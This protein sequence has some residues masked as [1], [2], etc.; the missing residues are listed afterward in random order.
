MGY[1]SHEG[2][3]EN[4]GFNFDSLQG[5]IL[6]EEIA[7][8][9]SR[10][11]I[12]INHNFQM[13]Q[14]YISRLG[15][16]KQ[17]DTYIL[18]NEGEVL[19]G[20]DATY[21]NFDYTDSSSINAEAK[22]EGDYY[23]I[24]GS[25][26]IVASGINSDYFIIS[27]KISNEKQNNG[28]SLI[29]IPKFLKG[30]DITKK[31]NIKDFN[32]DFKIIHFDNLK[33]PAENLLGEENQSLDHIFNQ[34]LILSLSESASSVS[35]AELNLKTTVEYINSQ[36]YRGEKVSQIQSVRHNIAQMFTEFECTKQF[37]YTLYS[38]FLKEDDLQNE[39]MMLKYLS[40][41]LEYKIKSNCTKIFNE[42]GFTSKHSSIDSIN[43]NASA[44]SEN[45]S[46]ELFD[47]ISNFII[48]SEL[49]K[50]KTKLK[51]VKTLVR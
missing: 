42:F 9:N 38:R 12:T 17:K 28:L 19:I 6:N 7:R 22:R 51:K 10:S 14:D 13:T 47:K 8:V 49:I 4:D 3:G 45:T 36:E 26:K 30:N 29:I 15:N 35:N 48:D 5:M 46:N 20:C 16:Q 33:V 27:C 1:F 21:E 44:I 2:S 11:F 25:K 24:N 39:I 32:A 34:N 50:T 43:S 18:K 40:S 31:L 37:L 41:K 23:L